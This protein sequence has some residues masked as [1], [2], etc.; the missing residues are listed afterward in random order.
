MKLE[1]I[2][3]VAD[4]IVGYKLVKEATDRTYDVEYVRDMIFYGM[5]DMALTYDGRTTDKDT[6]ETIELRWV[7]KR[8]AMLKREKEVKD[9]E[10][11]VNNKKSSL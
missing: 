2:K 7:S 11:L 5:E 8:Y 3:D 6:G 9:M 4:R 1:L 10:E